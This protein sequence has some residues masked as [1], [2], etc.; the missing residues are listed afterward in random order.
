MKDFFLNFFFSRTPQNMTLALPPLI[1]S[2]R[3][4]PNTCAAIEKR[5]D[6]KGVLPCKRAVLVSSEGV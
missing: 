4:A 5:A 1:F 3:D 2:R 6:P